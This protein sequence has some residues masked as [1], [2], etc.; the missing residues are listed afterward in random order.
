VIAVLYIALGVLATA[1]VVLQIWIAR[2]SAPLAG[3]RGGLV[4]FVRLFNA[5]LL[6]AALLLAAYTLFVR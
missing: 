1:L 6:A 5:V 4:L 2:S 3:Q